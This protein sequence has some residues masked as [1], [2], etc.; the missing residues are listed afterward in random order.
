MNDSMQ[1]V[2]TCTND[3]LPEHIAPAAIVQLLRARPTHDAPEDVRA[4]WLRRKDAILA[5]IADAEPSQ[6][7]GRTERTAVTA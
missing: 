6:I 2:R 1:H 3:P 4:A 7:V 5:A